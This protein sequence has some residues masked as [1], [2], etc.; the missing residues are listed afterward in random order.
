MIKISSFTGTQ[1]RFI[2][3]RHAFTIYYKFSWL[4]NNISFSKIVFNIAYNLKNYS[5]IYPYKT[6]SISR[7]NPYFYYKKYLYTILRER[8]ENSFRSKIKGSNRSK[9][10]QANPILGSH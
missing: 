2:K 8:S 5:K 3:T 6:L 4:I 10:R 1:Q 7:T 9:N